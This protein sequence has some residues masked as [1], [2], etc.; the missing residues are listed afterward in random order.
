MIIYSLIMLE[1]K[2][3]NNLIRYKKFQDLQ[4]TTNQI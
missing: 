4:N 2:Q 1:I 3:I